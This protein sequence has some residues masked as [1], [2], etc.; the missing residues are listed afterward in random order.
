MVYLL[1]TLFYFQV[2]ADTED[3][4]AVS[5]NRIVVVETRVDLVQHDLARHDQRLNVVVARAA[6]DADA[7]I[8]ER[9]EFC[10]L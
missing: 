3:R 9:L 5:D 8:N 6:E 7:A 4:L 2:Q 10:F 1:L